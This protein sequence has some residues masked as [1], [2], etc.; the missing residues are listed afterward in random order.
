MSRVLDE[1]IKS[2]LKECQ[3]DLKDNVHAL[4]TLLHLFMMY[5]GVSSSMVRDDFTKRFV[6]SLRKCSKIE[7]REYLSGS[8]VD[9]IKDEDGPVILRKCDLYLVQSVLEGY[10]VRVE[11]SYIQ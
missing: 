2:I 9:K 11:L 4:P 6:E 10:K 1:R 5:D 8:Y 7:V 3:L